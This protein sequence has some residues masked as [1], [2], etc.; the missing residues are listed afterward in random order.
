MSPQRA[1]WSAE[2][3]G[4]QWSLSLRSEVALHASFV[5]RTNES[6]TQQQT[7]AADRYKQCNSEKQKVGDEFA[8]S[9]SVPASNPFGGFMDH[10]GTRHEESQTSDCLGDAPDW[11]ILMCVCLCRAFSFDRDSEN[12]FPPGTSQVW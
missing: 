11:V 2:L 4:S 3:G 5:A 8:G 6:R 10:K 7:A 9:E 1:S 12:R